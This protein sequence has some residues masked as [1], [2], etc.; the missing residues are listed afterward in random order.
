M[1]SRCCTKRHVLR[2][3]A[4]K[5]AET[6]FHTGHLWQAPTETEVLRPSGAAKCRPSKLQPGL[7]ASIDK[8]PEAQLLQAKCLHGQSCR[9][10]A[11]RAA[12]TEAQQS[13]E[14]SEE[15]GGEIEVLLY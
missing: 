6:L 8:C 12:D 10:I 7:P 2:L 3:L 15:K 4:H 13:E 11:L 9:Q 14:A 1:L 5:P